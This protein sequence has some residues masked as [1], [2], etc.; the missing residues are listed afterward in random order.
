MKYF[1]IVSILLFSSCLKRQ[2]MNKSAENNCFTENENKGYFLDSSPKTID[3]ILKIK[4]DYLQISDSNSANGFKIDSLEKSYN[5]YISE[6]EFLKRYESKKLIYQNFDKY[7]NEQFIYISKIKIKKT[8]YA[9]AKN[10]LGFWLLKIENNSKSAYFLGLSFS[11]YYINK[12]QTL[13]L[14]ENNNIQFEGSFVKT[15]MVGGL[16]GYDVHS[17]LRD[18]VLFKINLKE[19]TMDSD[20]DGY[21]DIF[22]NCFALNPKNADSD[23]DGIN[24][25]DDLNPLFKSEKSKFTD[26][27]QQILYEKTRHLAGER[28]NWHYSFEF[29]KTD[30]DY[31][32]KVNP[33]TRILFLPD[34]KTKLTNYLRI[35]KVTT[36]GIS[37]IKIDDTN[38]NHF[39]I[40]ESSY[41]SGNDYSAE[42]VNGK[43]ILNII[44]GYVI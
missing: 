30:C 37:N 33:V 32:R 39:F 9:L 21:N 4:P 36:D 42:F 24:D 19:L 18:G 14:V 29:F 5:N 16:P 26:L 44:S 20:K 25:F 38:P 28:E 1:V 12:N 43:W 6:D 7:F 35:T 13:P 22:E 10:G 3:Q 15:Q 41:S 34:D 31:F 27:Y 2:K 8:S 23:E 17:S 40:S 11:N